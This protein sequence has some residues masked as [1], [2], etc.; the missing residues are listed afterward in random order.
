MRSARG[1]VAS[2]AQERRD[3]S[4]HRD[5]R[6]HLLKEFTESVMTMPTPLPDYY[7]L[8]EVP[9]SATLQ[10][11]KSSYRRLARLYHP[12]LN[13]QARE[14]RIKKLNEAY[15]VLSNA[16][17]RAAYDALLRRYQQAEVIAN[18]IRNQTTQ[19]SKPEQQETPSTPKMTWKE[20]LIGFILELR[21][22]LREN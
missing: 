18:A 1:V 3:R 5:S 12:D 4:L 8:L 14:D 15:D 13:K 19:Q 2:A 6:I 9:V 16:T 22:G 7:A 17:K 11:I 21:K 10:Q 20:G